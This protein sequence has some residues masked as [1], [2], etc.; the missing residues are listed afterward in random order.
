MRVLS[1]L[2]SWLHRLTPSSPAR[3]APSSARRG[4]EPLEQRRLL[5]APIFA[6]QG[7]GFNFPHHFF[8]GPAADFALI[9]QSFNT[10]TIQPGYQDVVDA[11]RAAGLNVILQFDDK[12]D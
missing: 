9:R 11:A 2:R 10:V 12:W 1:L 4:V 7:N 5:A 3:S 6:A 8:T